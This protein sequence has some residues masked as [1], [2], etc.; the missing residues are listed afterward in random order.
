MDLQSASKLIAVQS[1]NLDLGDAFRELAETSILRTTIKHFG[2]LSTA[3]VHVTC[4]GPLFHCTIDIQLAT[5]K[6][7][8]A[9]FQ[10]ED[11]HV[12]FKS[13][14]DAVENQLR[15]AKHALR[16]S[17]VSRTD[18]DPIPRDALSSS[19]VM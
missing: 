8:R 4:E 13:A 9:E 11:C 1:P 19:P 2:R 10:H 16:E 5:L 6:M 15:G 3:L 18:R 12:A 7:V 14:L 17:K